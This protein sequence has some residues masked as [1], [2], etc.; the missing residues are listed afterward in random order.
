MKI[1]VSNE[2]FLEDVPSQI[3]DW[4]KKKSSCR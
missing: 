1:K 3:S 2:I 4:I